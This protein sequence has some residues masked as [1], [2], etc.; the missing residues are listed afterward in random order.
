MS[1]VFGE[2]VWTYRDGYN[3]LHSFE[4]Q[5]PFPQW[6]Q[7]IMEDLSDIGPQFA[8]VDPTWIEAQWLGVPV[9]GAAIE[10][11]E[12]QCHLG[13]AARRLFSAWKRVSTMS[14]FRSGGALCPRCRRGGD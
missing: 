11:A 3:T 4:A 2:C 13:A 10:D 9:V 6:M 7:F 1:K 8:I 12:E 14:P 5:D